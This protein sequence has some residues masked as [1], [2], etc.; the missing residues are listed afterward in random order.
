MI[1]FKRKTGVLVTGLLM[2]LS[3]SGQVTSSSSL[4]YLQIDNTMGE[5]LTYAFQI[6][7]EGRYV[8]LKG[9]PYLDEEWREGEV[10]LT[11]DSLSLNFP[12]RYNIYGNEM[13]FVYDE[14]TFAISNPLRVNEINLDG[15]RFV[16]LTFHH[17]KILN[18]AYFEILADGDFQLLLRRE[19]VLEAGQR[20]VTP[21]HSQIDRHGF[22]TRKFYYYQS[23]M[24]GEPSLLPG[25]RSKML[26]MEE[27]SD[28]KTMIRD[29]RIHPSREGDLVALFNTINSSQK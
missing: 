1:P 12:M 22:A 8:Q 3:L 14:D 17:R 4:K 24:M 20:P 29:L 5:M 23:K 21:Y 26:Q 13:Q 16:Y 18:L 9:S 10:L 28:Q 25:T 2:G 11:G 27:F 19:S 7:P 15:H 6:R